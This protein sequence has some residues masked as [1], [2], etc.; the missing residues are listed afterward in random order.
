MEWLATPLLSN[1]HCTYNHTCRYMYTH[2]W[3]QHYRQTPSTAYSLLI[4]QATHKNVPHNYIYGVA[5]VTGYTSLLGVIFHKIQYI[6]TCIIC[7]TPNG[8]KNLPARK[9][10]NYQRVTHKEFARN[11]TIRGLHTHGLSIENSSST[12]EK[13]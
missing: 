11:I 1:I 8:K 3:R 7:L 4:T 2:A 12:L 9:G 13:S 6:T 10:Y 5:Q